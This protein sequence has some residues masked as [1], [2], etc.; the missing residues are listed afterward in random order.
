MNLEEINRLLPMLR[1]KDPE[2]Q[3]LGITATLEMLDEN[4]RYRFERYRGPSIFTGEKYILSIILQASYLRGE[5]ALIA[6]E[7]GRETGRRILNDR[8]RSTKNM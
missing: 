3:A 2:M 4:A 5:L 7:L 8:K 6:Y 1:S